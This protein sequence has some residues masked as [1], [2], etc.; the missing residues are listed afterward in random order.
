LLNASQIST[1]DRSQEVRENFQIDVHSTN[2]IRYAEALL[3]I[4]TELKHSFLLN[5]CGT[6]LDQEVSSTQAFQNLTNETEEI[7]AGLRQEMEDALRELEE[8]YYSGV[9]L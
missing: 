2:I 7:L 1:T 8:S 6:V 4:I 3:K 9:Q 5:D